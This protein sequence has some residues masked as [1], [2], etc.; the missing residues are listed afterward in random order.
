MIAQPFMPAAAISTPI[1]FHYP[2]VI[3]STWLGGSLSGL[4]SIFISTIYVFFFLKPE[5]WHEVLTDPKLTIRTIIFYLSTSL[6]FFLVIALEKALKDAEE[7]VRHRDEFLT[8][9]SH[10]LRT[11]ITTIKLQL[12]VLKY[13]LKEKQ[14]SLSSVDS[15]ERQVNRQDKLV[16]A[17][18]DVAMIESGDIGLIKEECDLDL[19]IAKAVNTASESLHGNEVHLDIVPVVAHC[20]R[21]RIEQAVF[22]LVH[23]AIRYGDKELI[24]VSLQKASSGVVIKIINSGAQISQ[25][26]RV[27]IFDKMKRPLL[28]NQV[29]GLGTGLYL[30]RHLVELHGG[31]IELENSN[32]NTVFSIELPTA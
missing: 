9:A 21:N 3:F 13:Q 17:M 32:E 18:L 27:K 19:V 22:N 4:V 5:L 14:I 23:N 7:A 1:V 28:S 31:K 16:S 30:A 24:K 10:E 20:D 8:S 2:L 29:Q 15:I 11:P 25:A 26:D 6:F 12:E